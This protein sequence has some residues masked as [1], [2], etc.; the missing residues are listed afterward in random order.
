[1]PSVFLVCFPHY[2]SETGSLPKSGAR[3]LASLTG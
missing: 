3:G 2:F 1:M